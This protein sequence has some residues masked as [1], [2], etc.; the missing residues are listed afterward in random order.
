[1]YIGDW[2]TG[3]A[4]IAFICVSTGYPNPDNKDYI[5][6]CSAGDKMV[7]CLGTKLGYHIDR[8][9]TNW[10]MTTEDLD[11]FLTKIEKT[12]LPKSYRRAIFY[13]FGHGNASHVKTANGE[14]KRHDI[15]SRFQSICPPDSDVFKTII[16]ECCREKID[17]YPINCKP[18]QETPL[19]RALAFYHDGSKHE[20]PYPMAKNLLVID[21]TN[22]NNKAH[23]FEKSGHGV[24]TKH[25][26]RL[27]PTENVSFDDLL[28]KVRAEAVAETSSE[29]APEEQLVD[30]KHLLMGSIYLLAESQG[31]GK[32]IM[33]TISIG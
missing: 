3:K 8:V 33:S 25:F 30:F 7:E 9:G 5:A 29:L 10:N 28:V 15:V 32:F 1:M 17:P 13:F 19:R 16:F 21:A 4:G 27:A 6:N 26:T 11:D 14:Y 18:Q 20:G 2:E 24:F 22:F 31:T 12:K 23:Y